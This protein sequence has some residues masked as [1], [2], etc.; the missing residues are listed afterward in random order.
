MSQKQASGSCWRWAAK[1]SRGVSHTL[2]LNISGPSPCGAG[3]PGGQSS[4]NILPFGSLDQTDIVPVGK[5]ACKADQLPH[6]LPS[7][8]RGTSPVSRAGG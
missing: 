1:P 6:L 7:H 2:G 4:P 5:W 3:L 8:L